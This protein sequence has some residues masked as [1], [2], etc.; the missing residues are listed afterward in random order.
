MGTLGPLGVK[1]TSTKLKEGDD[2]EIS[3]HGQMYL[4]QQRNKGAPTKRIKHPC[5]CRTINSQ[6]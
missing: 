2:N 4:H 3:G 1:D 6:T 5:D